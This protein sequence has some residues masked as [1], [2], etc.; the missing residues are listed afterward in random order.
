[1]D[2]DKIIKS[3]KILECTDFDT[4]IALTGKKWEEKSF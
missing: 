4:A 2:N 3:A 1:M